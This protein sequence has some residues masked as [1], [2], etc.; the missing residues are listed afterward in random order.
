MDATRQEFDLLHPADVFTLKDSKTYPELNGWTFDFSKGRHIVLDM[1]Q[2][3]VIVQSHNQMDT[4]N[5][6]HNII[7]DHGLQGLKN[8]VDYN[9][10]L[11]KNDLP[12]MSMQNL[13]RRENGL[14]VRVPGFYRAADG[15]SVPFLKDFMI[16][17][18]ATLSQLPKSLTPAPFADNPRQT[19]TSQGVTFL[20]SGYFKVDIDGETFP[21]RGQV[22][23]G[24][25]LIGLDLLQF[26]QVTL[27]CANGGIMIRNTRRNSAV[28]NW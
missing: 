25:P 13:E 22:T 8:L 24:V 21:V 7:R 15:S 2:K 12:Y 10:G 9:L 6:L 4:N 19:I 3:K 5:Y 27:D 23:D 26:F 28:A 16:D 11:V 1:S 18:G 14:Y 17:T 20:L